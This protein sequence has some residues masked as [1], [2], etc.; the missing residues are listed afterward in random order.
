[1]K[2]SRFRSSLGCCFCKALRP[3][4]TSGR[5]CSAARR[6]FFKAQIQMM[7]ESGDRRLT[8]RY[9]LLRQ[10][11]LELCQRDIRLLRHQLPD[12]FLVRGQSISLVP[13]EFCRTNA[14]RFAVQPTAP[15]YRADTHSKLLRSLRNSSAI[16]SRSNDART[17]IFR[18]RFRHPCWPPF[19]HEPCIRFVPA[20]E[21]RDSVF[22]GNALSYPTM[23]FPSLVSPSDTLL[24]CPLRACGYRSL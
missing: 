16:L 11:G 2:T 4:A 22:S 14:A 5:S 17:Q 23:S 7:Q 19:Q 12:Q 15:H 1:M 10:N 9:L 24:H 6:L 8:D 21:S 18:I 3:V 13:A 20:G